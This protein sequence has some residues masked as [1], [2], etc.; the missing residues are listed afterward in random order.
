MRTLGEKV[1]KPG[2]GPIVGRLTCQENQEF[3]S[4]RLQC[5]GQ[6]FGKEMMNSKWKNQ[7]GSAEQ[8]IWG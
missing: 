7:S 5:F 4:H 8:A 3:Q 6:T 1:G 2:R